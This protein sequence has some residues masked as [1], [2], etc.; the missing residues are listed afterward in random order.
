MRSARIAA[1]SLIVVAFASGFAA[2][3]V[4]RRAPIEI[5][6]YRVLA[7]DFHTHG[8]LWSDGVLTPFGLVLAA[9]RQ[10]LDAIAITGHD[11]V[12]DAKAGRWFSSLIGGPTILIGEEMLGADHHVIAVGIDQVIHLP[13]VAEQVA[14]VHRQGGVAI[15]AHPVREFWPGFA[16]G[17]KAQLDGSEICHPMINGNAKARTELDEFRQGV[18]L[19]AIGSSDFHG[20]GRIGECRTYVFATDNTAAA[21]V[22]AIR[23][24]RTVVYLPDGK[25][26]GD[27]KL[28][29]LIASRSDLTTTAT[30]DASPS[31]LDWVSRVCGLIGLVWLVGRQTRKESPTSAW[32]KAGAA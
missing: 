12:S 27:P 29:A 1:W 8:S 2:D 18:S 17:V 5:G 15:A 13:T 11:Q 14:E 24:H 20:F 30:T 4:P 6:G 23:A 7:A 22:D 26:Y 31:S 32:P 28:A 10:G 9:E 21:I 3:R 25:V 16:G 19:A